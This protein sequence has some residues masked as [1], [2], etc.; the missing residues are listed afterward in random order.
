MHLFSNLELALQSILGCKYG[1][2]SIFPLCLVS[3]EFVQAAKTSSFLLI[4][5][6]SFLL[7]GLPA[8]T[9]YKILEIDLTF[10]GLSSIR[11]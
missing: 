5:V 10:V 4:L 6:L 2:I 8:G 7:S 9:L 11:E 1:L 3:G